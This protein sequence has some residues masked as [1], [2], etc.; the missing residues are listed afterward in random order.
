MVYQT[1]NLG[2]T[3]TLSLNPIS[4]TPIRMNSGLKNGVSIGS[5]AGGVSVY[6]QFEHLTNEMPGLVN[7]LPHSAGQG[8]YIF[9]TG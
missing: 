6:F 9:T 3:Y 2:D 7:Y 5:V 1:M 8:R 4:Y